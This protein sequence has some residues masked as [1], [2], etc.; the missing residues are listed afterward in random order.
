MEEELLKEA[1]KEANDTAA[2]IFKANVKSRILNIASFQKQIANLQASIA[3]E[4]KALKEMK[5]EVVDES[6]LS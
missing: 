2:A 4:K 6:V 3:V 1:V 5:L